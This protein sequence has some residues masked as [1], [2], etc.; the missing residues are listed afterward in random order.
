MAWF[1]SNDQAIWIHFRALTT[2]RL[3]HPLPTK[4]KENRNVVEL[5]TETTLAPQKRS[6]MIDFYVQTPVESVYADST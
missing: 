1:G 2:K 4:N 5:L 3:Q 6:G